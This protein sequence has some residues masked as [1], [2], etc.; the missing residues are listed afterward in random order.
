M[1]KGTRGILQRKVMRPASNK[2]PIWVD[3]YVNKLQ[4]TLKLEFLR[5]EMDFQTLPF[6]YGSTYK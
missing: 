1:T 6:T 3:T 2:V 5:M 4:I